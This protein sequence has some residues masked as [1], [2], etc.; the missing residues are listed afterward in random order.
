MKYLCGLFFAAF[1]LGS[2]QAS[3]AQFLA[4]DI[5]VERRVV[6]ISAEL[7]CLV[8][9]NETIAASNA[10]LAQDLRRELRTMVKAG[11]SDAEIKEFMV[12]RYG[13]FILYR[14]PFKPLTWFLWIGPFLL[15]LAGVVALFRYLRERNKIV[16]VRPL[17]D[18]ERMRAQ[19]LIDESNP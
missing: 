17:T 10:D 12:T 11:K 2:T 13:D 4:Q 5:D 8:C 16:N 9:Q 14:P 7:R 19:A 18:E 3:E 1:L 15:M 6:A